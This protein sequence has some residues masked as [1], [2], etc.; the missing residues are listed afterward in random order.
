MSESPATAPRNTT[1]FETLMAISEQRHGP[2]T[3]KQ[4]LRI[5][6]LKRSFDEQGGRAA[7]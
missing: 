7:A 5:F 2:M 4:K 1:F 6:A 3:I